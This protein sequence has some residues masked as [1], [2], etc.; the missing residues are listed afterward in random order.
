MYFENRKSG[1]NRFYELELIPVNEFLS[2]IFA[3]WGPIGGES[4]VRRALR[5]KG[6]PKI[7]YDNFRCYKKARERKGY[8]EVPKPVFAIGYA[9]T[10]FGRY[11]STTSNFPNIP[12]PIIHNG[13]KRP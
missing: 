12:K 8:V 2:L 5:F 11:S 9:G 10:A 1:N 6:P 13:N 4:E 3:S 7:A